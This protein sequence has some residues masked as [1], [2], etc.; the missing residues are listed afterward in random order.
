VSAEVELRMLEGSEFQTV[1]V[2]MLKLREAKVVRMGSHGVNDVNETFFKTKTKTK[3]FFV[4]E[5]SQ[6]QTLVL[7]TRPTSPRGVTCLSFNPT[8]S[9]PRYSML[10]L[11]E[12]EYTSHNFI[13]FAICVLKMVEVVANLGQQFCAV[14]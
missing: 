3:T 13:V 8:D 10:R 1:G 12:N 7:R 6:D 11:V 9:R 14:F 4:L 2:A 5:A